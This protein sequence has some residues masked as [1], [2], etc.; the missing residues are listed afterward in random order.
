MRHRH[1]LDTFNDAA[2]INH[3]SSRNETYSRPTL[4]EGSV[5]GTV[6]FVCAKGSDVK[7]KE[8]VNECGDGVH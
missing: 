5:S 7:K 4:M 3:L 6:T 2:D 1:H 8:N